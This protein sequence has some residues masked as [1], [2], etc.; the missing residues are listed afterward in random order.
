MVRVLKKKS[1]V[2]GFAKKRDRLKVSAA[3][4][5]TWRGH[6]LGAWH[7]YDDCRA[8][9]ACTVC[10]KRVNVDALPDANGIDIGGEAVALNCSVDCTGHIEL[11]G[12]DHS[13]PFAD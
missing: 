13:E 12:I 5:A 7:N 6:T 8:Y 9:A 3:Q 2:K 4:S 1:V 11:D 10:G